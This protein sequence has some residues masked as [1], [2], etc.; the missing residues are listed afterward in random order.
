MRTSAS[1]QL[2]IATI[3]ALLV[4]VASACAASD[5]T[6]PRVTFVSP[7]PHATVSGVREG[8][9]CLVSAGDRSGIS[10]VVFSVDGI[11]TSVDRRRPW[12]CVWDTRRLSDG[13]HRLRVTAYDRAG[14]RRSAIVAVR[15]SNGRAAPSPPAPSPPPSAVS[16]SATM[17]SG[18]FGEFSS[19]NSGTYGNLSVDSSRGYEGTRSGHASTPSGQFN[20]YARG[21][22]NVDW[23]QGSDV[24]YGGAIY[25]PEDFYSRQQGDVDILRWDNWALAQRSQDQSGVTIRWDGKLAMLFKNLD[26]KEYTNLIDPAA[27]LSAGTW[28]WIDVRQRLG[29]DGAAVNELW[30]DG[31]QVGSST[32]HNSL[33]RRVTHHRI[34]LVA[35]SATQQTNSLDL[36]FD[37]AYIANQRLGPQ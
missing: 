32:T 35:E 16:R 11:R 4:P 30:V 12:S 9:R 27:P 33:G 8:R 19:I 13:R 22:W 24:W 23:D 28:H 34:G 6:P 17:E 25:L 7:K 5:R 37:R 29:G 18:G 10:R 20:K 21:I 2:A 26:T 15:V 14:N 31:Q 3:A 1:L 36:W